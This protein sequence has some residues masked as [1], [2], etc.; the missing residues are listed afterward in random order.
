M[1]GRGYDDAHVRGSV[2]SADWQAATALVLEHCDRAATGRETH[3]GVV[4]AVVGVERISGLVGTTSAD[5]LRHAVLEALE[6]RVDDEL[7]RVVTDLVRSVGVSMSRRAGAWRA[8]ATALNP[9]TGGHAIATDLGLLRAAVRAARTSFE[10]VPYY[11]DRYGERGARFSVSDSSWIVHL[12]LAPLPVATQQ[13]LWLADMLATRGM[14][15]WLME[16]HLTTMSDEVVDSGLDPG[17]LRDVVPVLAERRREH[18]PDTALDRAE[19]LVADRVASPPTSPVGRLVASSAAD[20][21]AGVP[22]AGA[23]LMGWLTDPVRTS[24]ADAAVLRD[25]HAHLVDGGAARP[26]ARRG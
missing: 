5:P 4:A 26:P 20:V 22:D 14:P 7:T 18:V 13:V 25:L 3:A 12:T 2:S 8:E 6:R 19:R 10:E 16:Q 1:T 15:T 23:P 17:R 9:E 21:R 24:P 11:R